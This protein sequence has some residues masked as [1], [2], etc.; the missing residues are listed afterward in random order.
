MV[1]LLLDTEH[2]PTNVFSPTIAIIAGGYIQKQVAEKLRAYHYII[3]VDRG[4]LYL[5]QHQI[6]PDLVVG[7]FDSVTEA[8][9]EQIRLAS[10]QYIGYNAD[11]EYTDIE[12][13][14]DKAIGMNPQHITLFGVT[15]T[16]L[17]HTLAN[18]H[19]LRKAVDAKIS[20]SIED[21]HNVIM[22]TNS[23]LTL[24]NPLFPY[25][26]LLP[27]SLTVTGITLTGFKYPLH[28]ATLKIGRS[29]G[30]SNEWN[31][32]DVATVQVKDG[33]LLI[34]CSRDHP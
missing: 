33:Y 23:L 26:S 19:L 6:S 27:L 34:I 3:G 18:I 8:E 15:G 11:K 25:I 5:V 29:L 1:F 28:N 30:V 16:R 17:D 13:A 7:D 21:D 2:L 10:R 9:H 14:F 22:L 24:R 12:L 20:C 4:A 32:V 31:A